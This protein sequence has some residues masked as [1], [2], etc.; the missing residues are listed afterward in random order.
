VPEILPAY[1]H[2]VGRIIC[3]FLYVGVALMMLLYNHP[4]LTPFPSISVALLFIAV[5]V[6]SLEYSYMEK[7]PII[8]LLMLCL[9]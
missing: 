9:V 7:E 8:S 4:S 3:L 6:M 5:K 1:I 2:A